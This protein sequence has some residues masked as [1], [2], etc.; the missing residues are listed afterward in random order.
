MKKV[1]LGLVILTSIS[2]LANEKKVVF[3]CGDGDLSKFYRIIDHIDHLNK[4]YKDRK[5]KSDIVLLTQGNCVKFV[6]ADTDGTEYQ[7]DEIPLDIDF[8]LD[9]LKKDIR[10]EQCNVTIDRKSID[11]SKLRSFIKLT[12]SAT[13]ASVDYQLSGY[14]IMQ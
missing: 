14:A 3:V 7:N 11:K 9:K 13:A 5:I 2:L 10:F 6:L 8:K 4:F 1:I 12:P